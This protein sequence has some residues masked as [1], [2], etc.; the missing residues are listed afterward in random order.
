MHLLFVVDLK[1]ILHGQHEINSTLPKE[2]RS[3]YNIFSNLVLNHS[4]LYNITKYTAKHS[5][6]SPFLLIF[7]I[8]QKLIC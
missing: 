4:R 5:S 3:L 1:W 7:T 8:Y 2:P 6:L